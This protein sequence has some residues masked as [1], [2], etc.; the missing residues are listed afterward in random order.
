MSFF[1]KKL[2]YF[3]IYLPILFVPSLN[4]SVFPDRKRIEHLHIIPASLISLLGLLIVIGLVYILL[5]CLYGSNLIL[6]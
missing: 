3:L 2:A 5:L 1:I 4:E 6:Y